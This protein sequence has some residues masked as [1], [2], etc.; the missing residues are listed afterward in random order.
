MKKSIAVGHGLTI[1]CVFATAQV[2]CS[3]DNNNEDAEVYEA[4]SENRG[5][6]LTQMIAS[7]GLASASKKLHITPLITSDLNPPTDDDNDDVTDD[8]EEQQQKYCRRPSPRVLASLAPEVDNTGTGIKGK[9]NMSQ[10][11]DDQ[12]EVDNAKCRSTND[13][14]QE[15]GYQPRSR[16]NS[17]SGGSRRRRNM[18]QN[19]PAEDS[20]PV[21]MA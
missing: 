19:A 11:K 6:M 20:R 13:D 1:L 9:W 18:L 4:I 10:A 8:A 21:V 12:S 7:N 5:G 2:M 16:L 14:G 15:F 3:Q 17:V